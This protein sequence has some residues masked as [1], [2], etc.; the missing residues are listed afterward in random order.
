MCTVERFCFGNQRSES[1]YRNN[2][3]SD[4]AVPSR[5]F[6]LDWARCRLAGI[7]MAAIARFR[8]SR[9][10]SLDR[11]FENAIAMAMGLRAGFSRAVFSRSDRD[12][13]GANLGL[14]LAGEIEVC[15]IPTFHFIRKTT[16]AHFC[17]YC[18]KTKYPPYSTDGGKTRPRV[19]FPWHSIWTHTW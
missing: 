4:R 10:F 3:I 16:S 18:P 8:A 19:F 14:F 11:T 7:Q 9:F 5:F 1:T 13:R 2:C 17:K 15:T 12:G 6:S